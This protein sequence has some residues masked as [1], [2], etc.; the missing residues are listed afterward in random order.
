MAIGVRAWCLCLLAAG[1]LAQPA[2]PP[3]FRV[4]VCTHFSQGKGYLPENLSLARQAGIRSIRDEATWRPVE[5]VKGQFAMPE[6]YDAYVDEAVRLGLEPLLIL[7]Y[8]NPFYDGGDKPISAEAVE[9]SVR[10]SEFLVRHFKG[11]V[12]LYLDGVS[13]AGVKRREY[14]EALRGW[15]VLR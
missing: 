2:R 10:Y 5:R 3:A 14:P 13:L 9:G 1:A 8:G 4:G 15:Q 7:D 6:A 12:K 11:K